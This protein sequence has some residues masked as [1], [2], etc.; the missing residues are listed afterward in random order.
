AAGK[1]ELVFV[2][3]GIEEGPDGYTSFEGDADLSGKIAMVLRFEPM[4]DLGRSQ[5]EDGRGWSRHASMYNKIDAI[6]K[7]GAA[8]I[9]LVNP[10]AADDP[11]IDQLGSV[12][13]MNFPIDIDIPAVMVTPAEADRIVRAFDQDS[14]PLLGLRRI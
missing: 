5:W 13:S 3:Y 1:G 10:P 12:T 9:V 7:R 2:G 11:R 6:A 4:T 8:G 14:R